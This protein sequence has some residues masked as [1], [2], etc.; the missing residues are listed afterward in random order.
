MSQQIH[1]SHSFSALDV[2]VDGDLSPCDPSEPGGFLCKD[3]HP[4]L[5]PGASFYAMFPKKDK[6]ATDANDLFMTH[7][8]VISMIL[9]KEV[10]SETD[11]HDDEWLAAYRALDHKKAPLP[12]YRALYPCLF[13]GFKHLARLVEVQLAKVDGECIS[14][15]ASWKKEQVGLVRGRAFEYTG[16]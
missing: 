8:E 4:F 16:Q 15:N 14:T 1:P 10:V 13:S 5:E 7:S 2:R 12:A 3:E 6:S 9:H 11:G